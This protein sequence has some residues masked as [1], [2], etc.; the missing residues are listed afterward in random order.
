VLTFLETWLLLVT[1]GEPT[2]DKQTVTFA[3]PRDPDQVSHAMMIR[4]P[5]CH[6]AYAVLT[7]RGAL[8]L[9]PPVEWAG[10][11]RAFVR[12]PDGNLFEISQVR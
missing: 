10:E 12:D 9:T 3:P 11:I 7:A 6:A 4:V 8:F 5:D 2:A 1:G